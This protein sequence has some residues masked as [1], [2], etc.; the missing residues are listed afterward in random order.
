MPNDSN[1]FA[2]LNFERDVFQRPKL[3]IQFRGSIGLPAQQS[4]CPVKWR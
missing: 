2:V 1:I 3:L 4:T